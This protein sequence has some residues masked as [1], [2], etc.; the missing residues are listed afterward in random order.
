MAPEE[1]LKDVQRT[2]QQKALE[3]PSGSPTKSHQSQ[4]EE[5]AQSLPEN[6]GQ[7]E[8]ARK[9]TADEPWNRS[10]GEGIVLDSM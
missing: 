4:V 7:A 10:K 6:M 5:N 8:D 2:D 1:Q 9:M 3:S